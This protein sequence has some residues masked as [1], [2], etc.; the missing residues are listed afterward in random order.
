MGEGGRRDWGRRGITGGGAGKGGKGQVDDGG[1]WKI[2]GIRVV[3]VRK[4]G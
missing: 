3:R 4:D 2:T 1:K